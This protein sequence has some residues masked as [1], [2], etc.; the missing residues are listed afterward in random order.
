MLFRR[1]RAEDKE[2][3]EKEEKDKKAKERQARKLLGRDT[4]RRVFGFKC[5]PDIPTTLKKEADGLHVPLFALAEH[6]LQ[7]GAIQLQQALKDP[8]EREELRQHLVEDHVQKRTIEKISRY[9]Q[10]AADWLADE[11]RRRF[12]LDSSVR[13][14]VARFGLRDPH[15][16]AEIIDLGLRTMHAVL[17][18][19]PPP[20]PLPG[21]GYPRR[22]R[23]ARR[24][25]REERPPEMQESEEDPEE[26]E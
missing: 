4:G 10:G 21:S 12:G 3:E 7:L 14:I 25:E 20:P 5:A 13:V 19:A 15:H 1:N 16:V 6:C 2:R 18:G 8:E 11:R 24:P 17:N 26:G 9:D 23:T 22:S